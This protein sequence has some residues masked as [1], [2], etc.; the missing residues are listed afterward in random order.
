M[1]ENEFLIKEINRMQDIL[2]YDKITKLQDNWK[3][4]YELDKNQV[5]AFVILFMY[6]RLPCNPDYNTGKI[7]EIEIF[8]FPEY[9]HKGICKKLVRQAIKFA[10]ENEIDIVADCRPAGYNLLKSMDFIDSTE[11]RCWIK[12][13]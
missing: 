4:F 7:A 5:K 12:L 9:R 3:I 13:S 11:K 2:G 6:T 1:L 10:K 8:T